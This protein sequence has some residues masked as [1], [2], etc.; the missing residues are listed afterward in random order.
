MKMS[1]CFVAVLGIVAV[2]F[3]TARAQTWTGLGADNKW[4]TVGNW[5]TGVPGSGSTANFVDAGNSKTNIS[6]SGGNQPIGTINFDT[7]NAAAFN[8]GVLSS[9]DKFTFDG[10]G[11][12]VIGS[13][14]TNVETI[15]AAI[16]TG[17][18]LNINLSSAPTAPGLK[19][20]GTLNLNGF[21]NLGPTG[22][23]SG[24]GASGAITIDAPI[25][26]QGILNSTI[27]T[28]SLNLNAQ[29]TYSGGTF[30]NA[31]NGGE[32]PAIR[33]GVDTVGSPGAVVSGPLGTGLITTQS[34]NPAVFQ[35]V[36]G[37]RT[38]ANDWLFTNAIFV[39]SDLSRAFGRYDAAQLDA[40]GQRYVGDY[41][42]SAYE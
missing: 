36:G 6:L 5:D 14:V 2:G 27:R 33:L 10:S 17:G 25:T 11:S 35:P 41:G 19:L 32:Q 21:L 1:K 3:S 30:L 39:G 12:I 18:D 28:G 9:G 7:A 23:T 40:H 16:D 13:A 31:T 38:I 22:T 34:G 29:S 8:L 15:N 37:D 4:S 42:P 26:G 20:E 24:P